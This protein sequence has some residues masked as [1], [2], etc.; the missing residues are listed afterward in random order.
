M[1]WTHRDPDS[2]ELRIEEVLGFW[3]GPMEN[4]LCAPA[5]R[6]AMFRPDHRHDE[7]IRARFG[8]DVEAALA[9]HR[10]HWSMT[11]TGRL[12]LV[13]LLDQFTRNIHRATPRAW[14]GDSRAL[15]FARE[16]VGRGDDRM[17]PVE[18]RVFLYLPFE[19]SESMADQETCVLLLD[20]LLREL[21]EHPQAAQVVRNYRD[22][23]QQ[24]RQLIRD[25]LRFPHRNRTLGRV[26]TDAERQWLEADG[27][28]FGQ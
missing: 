13:L 28:N 26:S 3:F 6:R 19:H 16:G 4:G 27:R 17:L 12:A 9:G 8:D 7:E 21:G 1:Q 14:S 24:H 10:D 2:T 20:H 25:F 15:D 5:R 23:A 18:Q 11:A 22:H